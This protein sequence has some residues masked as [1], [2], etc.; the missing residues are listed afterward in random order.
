MIYHR[1]P[2]PYPH[3]SHP[4]PYLY[5]VL[6]CLLLCLTYLYHQLS[7]PCLSLSINSLHQASYP[8]NPVLPYPSYS[9]LY[10]LPV[11]PPSLPCFSSTISCQVNHQPYL[12]HHLHH[13]HRLSCPPRHLTYQVH[14]LIH[15]QSQHPSFQSH[16]LPPGFLRPFYLTYPAFPSFLH[17]SRSSLNP[18]TALHAQSG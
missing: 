1:Q 5:P 11:T 12:R 10:H 6:P 4:C 8:L 9:P 14:P 13:P 18:P 16:C 7:F 3:L 15:H 2:Y 17:Q